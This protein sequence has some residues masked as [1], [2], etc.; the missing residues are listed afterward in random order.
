MTF[1]NLYQ[2]AEKS[3]ESTN[4]YLIMLVI[5]AIYGLG[6]FLSV[7]NKNNLFNILDLFSKNFF[8]IYLSAILVSKSKFS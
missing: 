1:K 3:K 6:P 4:V 7:V 5:W 8:G 2:F